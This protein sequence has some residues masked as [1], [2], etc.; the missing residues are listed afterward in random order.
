MRGPRNPTAVSPG[1]QPTTENRQPATVIV[2]AHPDCL[3]HVPG[4]GHPE[5]PARLRA[6]LA[7]LNEPPR[8]DWAIEEEAALPPT[9]DTLGIV[10]WLHDAAHVE[11]L[12][13]ASAAAPGYL[14]TRDC[15]VSAGTFR[16]AVAAAGLAV[17]AALDLVNGKLRRAFLLTR[18]PGH[19]ASAERAAGCCFFNNVALAAEV[20]TRAWGAPVLIVDL[21]L[22]HGN[23]TQRIFS[24]RPDVGYLSVHRYPY[25]P[26][27]GG[28]DEIGDGAGQG[29]TVNVP[30][31]AG[32]G[33]DAWVAALAGGLARL[34]GNLHPAVVLV[35][36][37]FGA[38]IDE[39]AG[40]MSLTNNGFYRLTRLLVEVAETWSEGQV[41][42]LLEGG[43]SLSALRGAARA[44]VE[45]L[46]G[47]SET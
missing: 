8:G 42:S 39:V 26:G 34:T 3:A 6:I 12:A 24:D 29:L 31:A 38:H 32:A 5:T 16:A 19:H 20:V 14:D 28:G 1:Q 13:E 33:D 9:E 18:P 27:T 11:R 10:R 37:G 25:Y 47:G 36:A 45:A 44:H 30:L 23:G 2:R 21:D 41:I 46:A 17:G 43:F 7:A 40:G 4:V 22:A 35:S 15:P